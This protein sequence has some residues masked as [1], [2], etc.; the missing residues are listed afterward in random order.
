MTPTVHLHYPAF[1]FSSFW[2]MFANSFI[3]LSPHK[4][5]VGSSKCSS[6]RTV[7]QLMFGA[8]HGT[9]RRLGLVFQSAELWGSV[10]NK[11]ILELKEHY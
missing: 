8:C 11:E 4:I 9:S 1:I 7:L 10:H 3:L 2:L 5:C 6:L